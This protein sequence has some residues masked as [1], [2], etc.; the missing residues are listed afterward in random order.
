M[1]QPV[2]STAA[3]APVDDASTVSARS[4][5][6]VSRTRPP[7]RFA[8]PPR[9]G[10]DRRVVSYQMVRLSDGPDDLRTAEVGRL[11][12]G[13]EVEILESADGYV[14][15]RTPDG[16]D[17]WVPGITVLRQWAGSDSA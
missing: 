5:T 12:R 2:A 8:G 10:V 7:L 9:G 14:R 3:A 15:V 4:W 11:D 1:V 13:D 17:G 16:L 6:A